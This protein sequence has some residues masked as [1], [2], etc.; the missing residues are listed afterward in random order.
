MKHPFFASGRPRVFAHRGGSGLAPE[1]T[2]AAF[3]HGLELGA[4]GLELDVHL[5]RD[6]VVVVHHDPRLDR[7]TNRCGPINTCTAAELAEVDAAWWFR[8]DGEFCFRGRG[9]CVPTLATVLERFPDVPIIIELKGRDLALAHAVVAVVRAANAV[10]RVCLGCFDVRTLRMV[11]ALEPAIATSAARL[12][13]IGALL[14]A[15]CGWPLA[16]VMYAGFQVPE[17]SGPLR[18]VS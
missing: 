5:S 11:R 17:R 12:E 3:E 15:T 1:N 7:T 2:L 14:W 10:D 8:R 16:S 4:D 13:V 18:V 9:L 6:G